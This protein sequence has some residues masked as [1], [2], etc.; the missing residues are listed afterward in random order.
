MTILE[1]NVLVSLNLIVLT[2][3]LARGSPGDVLDES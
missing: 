1:S 3:T 2:L